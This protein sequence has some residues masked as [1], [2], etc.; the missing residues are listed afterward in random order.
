MKHFFFKISILVLVSF[1][2]WNCS[3][4]K[5]NTAK[6]SQTVSTPKMEYKDVTKEGFN[7]FEDSPLEK[8][9]VDSVYATLSF[10]EKLGQ[11]FM[12]AAYS[13]KDT[14]HFNAI[15]KLVKNYKIGGLIFFQGGPVRQAKLTNRFQAQSKVPLFIGNDAEWGLSMRL[16]STYKYPWNMTLGA[17]KDLKLIEELGVQMGKETKRLGLQFNF[18]PVLDINTNP[19]NP[20][21][22]NRSFGESKDEVTSHAIALM[23]GLQNQ[24]VFATGKHFPG[25]GDTETDSHHTLP[26]VNFSEERLNEIEFFPYKKMFNLGLASVMV[27]HLNV[28][29]VESRENFPTSIS[30]NVVSNIL[31][32]Q[33]GFNGLIFTDALNM[34]GAS[35]FKKPGEIDL[36]AFLAGNDVMLFAED[37]PTA[38]EKFT[39]AY[40]D[41]LITDER[42]EHSVKKILKYKYKSGL[43][44]YKPIETANLYTDLNTGYS[45]SLQYKLYENAITVIKNSDETLPITNYAKN[46]IAFVKLGDDSGSK[47][48]ATLRKY[49]NITEVSH[50]NIDSLNLELKKFD[51]VIIGYHVSDKSWWKKHEFNA[52]ELDW[53]QK[54]SESNTTILDVFSKPYVLMPLKG[55]EHLES[56]IVSYQ[57]GEIAQEVSAE[58]IFGA[59]EAKGVLPVSV[60]ED[61]KVGFGLPT[62][63]INVL[64]FSNPETVGMNSV[65]LKEIDAVVKKAIDGKMTPGAQVLVA[66]KG[67]IVYQKSYGYHTYDNGVK[68]KNSDIYDIASLSKI[69]GTLPNVMLDYDKGKITMDTRLGQMV[70]KAKGTDKDSITFKELLSHYARL[71]AWEPFYKSTI[72]SVTK[73]PLSK[74]YRKTSTKG[75]TTQVSEN[76]FIR[77]TYKDSIIDKIIKSK[78]LPKKEYRYS[79]F[80]FILLKEYLETHHKR[81]LDLLA[82]E[83]FFS[84]LGMNN[85]SYNPLIKFEED[86][87]PPTE[88]DKYFRYDVIQGY[89]HD[90]AA[91]MQGGVAGHAGIFS[92]SM[93]VAKMMQLF[94]NK[95]NYGGIQYFSEKTMNDF[96]TCNY[97]SEGNRRGVGF[98]KPQIKGAGP[99]CGCASVTSFGHTGF[100]GTMA[101]ADPEKE[102]IYIF[103]SNRTFPDSNATNKLSKE[104]IREDIQKIIYDAIIN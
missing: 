102:L 98:D 1:L 50:T 71:Q 35:N 85:T 54:I 10:E 57:N 18:A 34:K 88:K 60:N 56:I 58:L 84:K 80:T 83:N 103:L 42:I 69:V 53:I 2:I 43:N 23:K 59:I 45:N 104:N 63:K 33:L 3:S 31:K 65:K 64:G 72:D 75:F 76:L 82:E 15:E 77:D 93:D 87:I 32:K 41:T 14:I 12:V 99:T 66:R 70:H 73:R 97:C 37:V 62:K 47:F 26:K 36:A 39:Q 95:G 38:I 90:M 68:V 86:I 25:H 55:M 16:D 81:S 9:W 48:L 29:S 28:P 74:Y 101:W 52:K 6:T 7:L 61:F 4:V 67:K 51:K 20:I 46:K 22:G 30:Y 40:K 19:N 24:N 21:I 17:I 49:T 92:N 27:A 78:L 13:N 96:N 11:L 94:L 44:N 89:V 8:K 91:A 100:T 79:D 5:K